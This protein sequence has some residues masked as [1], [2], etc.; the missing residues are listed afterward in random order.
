MFCCDV[1]QKSS[2]WCLGWVVKRDWAV[3]RQGRVPVTMPK[4]A[5]PV[6]SDTVVMGRTERRR[7]VMK[8]RETRGGGFEVIVNI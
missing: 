2:L 6:L 4:F 1:T 3:D 5:I 8:R 7:V